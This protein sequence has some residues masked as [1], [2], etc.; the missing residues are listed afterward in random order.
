MGCIKNENATT[1]EQGRILRHDD[2]NGGAAVDGHFLPAE[3]YIA[4]DEVRG[5]FLYFQHI[6]AVD[7]GDGTVDEVHFLNGDPGQG[8][9]RI[10]HHGTRDGD[11]CIRYTT[12]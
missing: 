10:I 2:I 11:L 1:A 6:G 3:A 9:P 12:E 4:K 5:T 7:I 8:Q